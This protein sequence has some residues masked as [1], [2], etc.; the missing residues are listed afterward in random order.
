[1]DFEIRPILCLYLGCGDP[2]RKRHQVKC[3]NDMEEEEED[4]L[5]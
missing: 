2:G 1:M 4:F 5:R 3:R